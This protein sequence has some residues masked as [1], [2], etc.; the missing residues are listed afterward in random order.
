MDLVRTTESHMRQESMSTQPT[1]SGLSMNTNDMMSVSENLPS[2]DES[3]F[4]NKKLNKT[5][6][7][8]KIFQLSST[9]QGYNNANVQVTKNV[10]LVKEEVSKKS[11]SDSKKRMKD[12]ENIYKDN[13]K[14]S[15][16]ESL[17]NFKLKLSS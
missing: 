6:A 3:L 8:R 11:L 9:N 4:N 5:E 7:N 15:P 1:L 13:S 12:I 14:K 16:R 17:K 2:I 10:G